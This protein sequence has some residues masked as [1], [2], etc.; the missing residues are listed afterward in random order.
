MPMKGGENHV[1]DEDAE[2]R[3]GPGGSAEARRQVGAATSSYAL[4]RNNHKRVGSQ[5]EARRRG[6]HGDATSERVEEREP[7]T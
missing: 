1:C 6:A 2:K 4:H 3:E 7:P 5:L